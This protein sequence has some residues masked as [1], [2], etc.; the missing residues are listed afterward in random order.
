MRSRRSPI[1]CGGTGVLTPTAGGAILITA[2]AGVGTV[3]MIPGIGEEVGLGI[4]LIII[5]R[6]IGGLAIGDHI[7]LTGEMPIR[8]AVLI[9]RAGAFLR[10]AVRLSSMEEVHA[11]LRWCAARRQ[12]R[13]AGW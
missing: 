8:L 5:T 4:I 6:I 1:A 7:I 11:V 12:A 2:G 9:R 13:T 3:G 10:D